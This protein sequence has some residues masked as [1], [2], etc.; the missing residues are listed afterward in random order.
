MKRKLKR[1]Y[2]NN[3]LDKG[4]T[5]DTWK[6]I[7]SILAAEDKQINIL[8]KKLQIENVIYSTPLEIAE[9]FN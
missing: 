4:N 2:Y 1:N 6:V 5:K 9:E 7:N 8:P 3:L